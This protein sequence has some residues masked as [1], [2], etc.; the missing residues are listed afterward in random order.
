MSWKWHTIR[1]SS[2]SEPAAIRIWGLKTFALT[3]TWGMGSIL[4][5]GWIYGKVLLFETVEGRRYITL[6]M[7]VAH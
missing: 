7:A 1:N 3:K 6:E 2:N 5:S 4:K